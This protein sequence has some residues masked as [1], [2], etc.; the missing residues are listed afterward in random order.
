MRKISIIAIVV[1][2]FLS[3]C[4]DELRHYEKDIDIKSASWSRLDTLEYTFTVVDTTQL[5]DLQCNIRNTADYA[6]YNLYL[7][8][9]LQDSLGKELFS[10]LQELYL[11]DPQ[12]GKSSGQG[13]Y[14]IGKTLDDLYDHRFPLVRGCRFSKPGEYSLRFTHQMRDMEELTEIVAVGLRVQKSGE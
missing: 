2:S 3:A 9:S 8:Y 14:L 7:N 12:T 6:Y 5:Y 10:N 1:L 13:T 11:F 4:T